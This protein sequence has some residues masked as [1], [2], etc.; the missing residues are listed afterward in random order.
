MTVHDHLPAGLEFLACGTV[1]NTT[2][3]P[4]FS[5]NNVEYAGA[6]RLDVATP[7]LLAD[8]PAASLVETVVTDPDGT[9]PLPLAVYT[10]VRWSLGNLAAGEVQTITY[11]AGI[12]I[13]ENTTTWSAPTP[14][15]SGAQ[16][17]NLDNNSGPETTDE[18][19]LRNRAEVTG[20]YTGSLGGGASNPVSDSHVSEISAE[21]IR[22]L[23]SV[24]PGYVTQTTPSM[25]TITIATSEYRTADNIDVTDTLPD[26]HCPLG[27]INYD[28]SD[29][30]S[31]CAPTGDNPS[32]PYTTVAENPDGSWTLVWDDLA[33]LGAS[34]T[35]V[36]TFPSRVRVNSQENG[37]DH[38]PLVTSDGFTNTVS[39]TADDHLIAGIP[40]DEADG[41]PD[42]DESTAS[43]T[44]TSP[45][46]EKTVS[47]PATPGATLDCATATYVDADNLAAAPFAYRP[48]DHVCY[49]LRVDVPANLTLRNALVSDFL[50]TG[51]TFVTDLG[52]TANNDITDVDG[53]LDF[54]DGTPL[55]A[56]DTDIAWEIGTSVIDGAR[57]LPISSVARTWEV[58]FIAELTGVPSGS[59]TGL[60]KANLMKLTS[61]NSAGQAISLRDLAAFVAVEP[62]LTLAKSEDDADDLVN[63]G[64][65]VGFTITVAN[66]ADSGSNLGDA[67]YARAESITLTDDLPAPLTC[68][69]VS[70][71]TVT[72]ASSSCTGSRI[73]WTVAGLD[74]EASIDLTYTAT[75]PLVLGPGQTLVNTATVASFAQA[76]NDGGTTSYTP[77]T[78]ATTTLTVAGPTVAK[79][80]QSGI[81]ESGNAQNTGLG[82]GDEEATIGETVD[83]RIAVDLPSGVTVYDAHLEDDLPAGVTIVGGSVNAT[84]DLGEGAGPQAVPT[85]GFSFSGGA[86]P[87]R[88]DFPSTH[89]SGANPDRLVITFSVTVDDI[90]T[91]VA[92]VRLN[93]TGS[94]SWKGTPSSPVQDATSA[95]RTATIVEPN[96]QL[97][98]TDDDPDGLVSVGQTITYDLTITN[99]D[100]ANDR[101]ATA[102]DLVVVDTLPTHLDP[103]LPIPD[104]GVWNS[105]PRTITWNSATTPSLASLGVDATAIVLSY[106]VTAVGPIP[107]G[108]DL[109]NTAQLT[110]SSMAGAATGERT[111]YSDTADNTVTTAAA[112]LTKA[113]DPDIGP[114]TIGESVAFELEVTVPRDLLAYDLSATDLVPDGLVF[115]STT[116]ITPSAACSITGDS[117]ITLTSI[118]SSGSTDIAFFLGD[119]Q[120][121][122]G[123]CQIAIDYTAHVD[124]TYNGTGS[125]ADGTPVAA[126]QTLTNRSRLNWMRTDTVTSTPSDLGDLPPAWDEQTANEFAT[127]TIAEPQLLIDKDVTTVTGCDSTHVA[128][129]GLD[130]DD[131]VV[132]PGDGPFTFTIT[133]R[134]SGAEPAHDI[135]ITDQP[136][137]ELTGI[138]PGTGAADLT[139]PWT[140]GDPGMRWDVAGPLAP[141][142]DL[143]LTYTAGLVASSSLS[144]STV[145]SNS[146]DVPTYYGLDATDR[147]ATVDERTYG[148]TFGPVTADTVTIDP[149]FPAVVVAKT[150]ATGAES[151]QAFVSAGFE[152]RIAVS[153]TAATAT[154]ND[155]D[156][157]D[158]LPVN[159]SY[160]TGSAQLCTPTCAALANPAV[161]G[162]PS[163]GYTLDWADVDDLA[164]SGSF[165]IRFTATP[166]AAAADVPGSGATVDHVNT[167]TATGDD[168][169]GQS[170]NASGPYRSAADTASAQ[171]HEADLSLDKEILSTAPY[172]QGRSVDYRVTITNSGPDTATGVEVDEILDG[173][174]LLWMATIA[175]DGSYD[176]TTGVWDVPDLD[177]SDTATL[178]LRVEIIG[179]G[180]I[181]NRAQVAAS[182]QH[183]PDSAPGNVSTTSEDDD[184]S[185]T[186]TA[187]TASIG[188]T[189][190]YD[191]DR[192]GGDESTRGSEPGIPGVT[193]DLLSAG[194][195]GIFATSD[196][197]LGPDGV[198]AT[199]DD[200]TTTSVTTDALGNYAFTDLPE[201]VYRIVVDVSTLPGGAPGWSAT[202]DDDGGDDS[203]S[204]D[205]ALIAAA[206]SYVDADFSYTGTGSLGDELF[207]DADV[208]AD[209][210]FSGPDQPIPGVDI[211][212]MWAGPDDAFGTADDVT[213]PDA[214]SSASGFYEFSNLPPGDYRIGV[215]TT[216]GDFPDGL[217]DQTWDVGHAGPGGGDGD[218]EATVDVMLGAAQDR[219]DVDFSFAGSGSIGDVV[220]LDIDGDG[221]QDDGEPGLPDVEVSLVWYGPDGVVGGGNDRSFSTVTDADG[222]YGFDNLPAGSF[223]VTVVTSDTDFPSGVDSSHDVDGPST[224]DTAEILLEPDQARTDVDFG[225][226]GLGTIGDTVWL[227][228]DGSGTV[229]SG[230]PGI[231]GIPIT[232][233]WAGADGTFGSAD[234]VTVPTT[235]AADGAWEVAG[236][237]Y[238]PITVDLD[239]GDLPAGVDPTHDLDGVGSPHD[240]TTSLSA[241]TEIRTDVDFG[242]R[243]SGAVG[244]RVWVDMDGDGIVDPSE[245]GLAGAVVTITTAGSDGVLGT[246]DDLSIVTS[247][248]GDGNY[249]VDGLP[250]GPVTVTVGGL[251]SDHV[252]ISDPDGPVDGVWTGT[253]GPGETILTL[254]FGVRPDADLSVAKTHVGSF[255]VGQN[256]VFAISIENAG[257]ARANGVQLTDALPSGLSFVAATGSPCSATRSV[258]TCG[259]IDLEPG[260]SLTVTMF[261][262]VGADAAPG[263]ANTV[264]VSSATP[265]R[266]PSNN[267]DDDEVEVPLAQLVLFKQLDGGLFSGE[268]ATY[269]LTVSNHGPSPAKNVEVTDR[270]PPTLTYDGV[271]AT[272]DGWSCD[273]T[274]GIVTC[275]LDESLAVG[276]A[277]TIDV[278]VRVAPSATGMI[279]NTA[280]AISTTG[281]PNSSGF[282]ASISSSVQS[283]DLAFTGTAVLW[284]IGA[285]TILIAGGSVLLGLERTGVRRQLPSPRRSGG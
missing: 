252:S 187:G 9:G 262:S 200:I 21:D 179:T 141:G 146:A 117:G 183:D 115:D 185:V 125:P 25:W 74:A 7:D 142:A 70:V 40:A 77:G 221:I 233:T 194:N 98:K 204:G 97:A 31:E 92:G 111:T 181:T 94:F 20:V 39:I 160:D 211:G 192:S 107:V 165:E 119:V 190:W 162:S 157:S 69:D 150:T 152:W 249:L 83:Y 129:G 208:S 36:L 225:Y 130:D 282:E 106:D 29:P 151:G 155:V 283:R 248:D 207:W 214:V 218:P 80:Q 102:H 10:H 240:V 55:A 47:A 259:P 178:D 191:V 114:Y 201:G 251:P 14:P 161:G 2:D 42:L 50:P 188:S 198:A 145:I 86:N 45:T 134:N 99:P 140:A 280:E 267:A 202:Y 250:E 278:T 156:V 154:A 184:A 44:T 180:S 58:R 72:G 230:E 217:D 171:I 167:A 153:N 266:N 127:V 209:G 285:G 131:C 121:N 144:N 6:A 108:T 148:S 206:P 53:P 279:T 19:L 269:R 245:N 12:P 78:T 172:L 273:H 226:V 138:T 57:Y 116:A 168:A 182:E 203:R 71:D 59:G 100:R 66:V 281:P 38:A 24:S 52:P 16:A 236:L 105:T 257:P 169:S 51:A 62:E 118:G 159:W 205:I 239:E 256:G 238:G 216:D 274:G 260:A 90:G 101:G 246:D 276:G 263:V 34:Q 112:V 96:P 234:D 8:C 243:G 15:T 17:A 220:W 89:N 166:S 113:L 120:A 195:D 193:V 247:T 67:G 11:A 284:V 213:Y 215:E 270:L 65:A 23:K 136:D 229:D 137:A 242:Y 176:E 170:A 164:P 28:A 177:D 64:D 133:V 139:D 48:G 93:D 27:P 87:T 147:T 26:G 91:N 253:L 3:A 128:N 189:V 254:E 30:T 43:Q 82:T 84:I 41:T 122:G 37:A 35:V 5:G 186:I 132:Q 60:E 54:S 237:P 104:G 13:R 173:G 271:E 56:G 175:V 75:F 264:S 196:D 46:I 88:V 244:D 110:A 103:V 241:S 76:N 223:S 63:G 95:I 258:V 4:T 68:S 232:V 275:T 135:V 33:T 18:Q 79:T 163:T 81:S 268:L 143:T 32:N 199:G 219:N 61:Q 123:D 22:V 109:E 49:T 235:T 212:L 126:G 73:T 277:L 272:D 222:N 174:D 227:D 228:R 255:V 231:G 224:A 1:D 149:D 210:L 265:D 261:V 85:T 158:T 124:Q 197:Y